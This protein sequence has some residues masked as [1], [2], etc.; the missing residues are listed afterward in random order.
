MDRR[1]CASLIPPL[2]LER[3]LRAGHCVA[4][5]GSISSSPTCRRGWG[6][7]SRHQTSGLQ[8]FERPANQKTELAAR[9]S[10][11]NGTRSGE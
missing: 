3:A 8:H 7:S 2:K 11:T 5:I 9:R 1:A 6:R 10:K 4:S